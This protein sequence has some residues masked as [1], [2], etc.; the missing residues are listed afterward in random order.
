MAASTTSLRFEVTCD[1]R[2]EAW[3]EAHD[4][5]MNGGPEERRRV[6]PCTGAATVV[7]MPVTLEKDEAH[8]TVSVYGSPASVRQQPPRHG[9]YVVRFVSAS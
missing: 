1:A 9:A 6:V 4:P 2:D 8:V 7:D 3:L 5:R